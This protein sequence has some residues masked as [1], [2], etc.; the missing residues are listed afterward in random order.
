MTMSPDL[1]KAILALDSYNRGYYQGINGLGSPGT[2]IGTAEFSQQSLIE[3]GSDEFR[4]SFYAAAYT[5]NSGEIVISY[6][7]TDS[8]SDAPSWLAG[9][10]F[11]TTQTELGAA[12]YRAVVEDNVFGANVLFTGHS[13][14]GGIAGRYA[15]VPSRQGN[16]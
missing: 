10:G 9:G 7:G 15:I 2:S 12:F 11:Q 6:R 8:L 14:G 16:F 3:S 4:A 1:F 13:H 5:L